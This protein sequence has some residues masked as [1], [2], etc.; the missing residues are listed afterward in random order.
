MI[1]ACTKCTKKCVLTLTLSRTDGKHVVDDEATNNEGDKAKDRQERSDDVDEL[2]NLVLGFFRDL[3]TS[4]RL[5]SD[6][7]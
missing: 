2:P 5:S 4:Q 1:L 7:F 6:I 3:I